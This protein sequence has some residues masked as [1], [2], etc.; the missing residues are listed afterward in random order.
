MSDRASIFL[1]QIVDKRF[2]DLTDLKYLNGEVIDIIAWFKDL[3]IGMYEKYA[4]QWLDIKSAYLIDLE[5]AKKCASLYPEAEVTIPDEHGRLVNLLYAD[6]VK[7]LVN[8]VEKADMHLSI[9]QEELIKEL[10][11]K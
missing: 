4:L 10:T 2:K 8:D 6:W 9:V 1:E 5:F 11:K 7:K 3:R